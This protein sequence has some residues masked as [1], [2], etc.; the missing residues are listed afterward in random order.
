MSSPNIY[1]YKNRHSL[2]KYCASSRNDCPL[3][4]ATTTTTGNHFGRKDCQQIR[5]Q[6]ENMRYLHYSNR[7]YS[8]IY[9]IQN[10]IRIRLQQKYDIG[11]TRRKYICMNKSFKQAYDASNRIQLHS[12]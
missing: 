8:Q 7:K 4:S 9:K 5:Y 6:I 2:F 3:D 12:Q 1:E 10:C 11:L